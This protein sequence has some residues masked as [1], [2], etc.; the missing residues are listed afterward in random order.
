MF[1]EENKEEIRRIIAQ[2]I[3]PSNPDMGGNEYYRLLPETRRK[4]DE[5]IR[6]LKA[7]EEGLYN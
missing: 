5:C 4:I 6:R 3:F 2:T 7:Y 1:T